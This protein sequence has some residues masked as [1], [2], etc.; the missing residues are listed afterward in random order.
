MKMRGVNVNN[1][2]FSKLFGTYYLLFE[3]LIVYLDEVI[4]ISLVF[5]LSKMSRYVKKFKDKN[6]YKCNKLIFLHLNEYKLLGKNGINW[7]KTE[8]L[9]CIKWNVSVKLDDR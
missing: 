3:Y 2:V 1:I 5:L 8:N 4:T 9:K 7:T 6:G